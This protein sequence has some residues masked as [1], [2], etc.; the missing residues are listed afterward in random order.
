MSDANVAVNFTA[1]VGDLLSGISEARD[2][3]QTLDAPIAALG[4]RYQALGASLVAAHAQVG[5]A[6]SDSDR[7]A[8]A[9]AVIDARQA[10]EAQLETLQLGLK[11][12]LALYADD[13]R[14]HKI[15]QA[16]KIADTVA[17]VDAEYSARAAML[18]RMA[19]LH[20]QSSAARQE[21]LDAELNAA[22]QNEVEIV[23][24]T[25]Q[26][27]NAQ[28]GEYEKLATTITQSFNGQI[29]GLLQG[30]ESWRTAFKNT[31]EELLIKFIEWSEQST[32]RYLAGEAA[33]TGAT[34]SGV[35]ARTGAEQAGAAASLGAHSASIVSSILSSA[36]EAFAGVFGFLAP[37]L[38]PLAAGPAAS[39]QATVASMAGAVASADIGMWRAPEDMLTL[40]HHNELIMPAAEAGQFR[41]MLSGADAAPGAAQVQ[42]HPTT[43]FHV[44][45][46]DGGS[47]SQW[48][49]GNSSQMM[50]AIDEAVR[51]GAGLGLRRLSGR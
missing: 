23:A 28:A 38:G 27:V 12:A 36:A 13:A 25:Q 14:Q 44:S 31:L 49:R 18:A 15:S 9:N 16:Q 40:I 5:Q 10:A 7:A 45:A 42:I 47:V 11:S 39:A 48:L 26:A 46:L 17:A 30:T 37:V 8:S 29:R 4:D 43:H 24:L 19:G 2:A 22:R 51:H 41:Q 33:K 32:L 50:K 1:S 3:I 21:A 20:D 6:L 35:A 34:V